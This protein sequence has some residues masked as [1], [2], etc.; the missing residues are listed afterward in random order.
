MLQNFDL[1]SA[2]KH[3]LCEKAPKTRPSSLIKPFPLTTR[4]ITRYRQIRLQKVVK[5]S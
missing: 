4:F 3:H 1:K 5:V 2:N